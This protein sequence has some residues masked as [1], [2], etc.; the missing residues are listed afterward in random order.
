M[1]NLSGPI[2]ALALVLGSMAAMAQ[3]LNPIQTIRDSGINTY[4][5][6]ALSPDG[7]FAYQCGNDAVT[8]LSRDET[9]GQLTFAAEYVDGVDG[10]DGVAGCIATIVSPDG[11]HLYVGGF[12]ENKI[13]QFDRDVNTG[14]LTLARVY[15]D[16]EN[17]VEAEG[18]SAFAFADA[19]NYLYASATTESRIVAF[20]RD[21]STG[22]LTV[23]N[24]AEGT[25]GD[26]PMPAPLTIVV[27]PDEAFL[28][29]GSINNNVYTCTRNISDGSIALVQ[30]FASGSNLFEFGGPADLVIAPDGSHVYLASIAANQIVQMAPDPGTG[31]LTEVAAFDAGTLGLPS[32]LLPSNIEITPDGSEIYVASLVDSRLTVLARDNVTGA[33]SLV[34]SQ[35][36]VVP[37]TANVSRSPDGAHLYVSGITDSE[38]QPF[39]T[40]AGFAPLTPT[41]NPAAIPRLGVQGI[42]GS[43]GIAMHPSGDFVYVTGIVEAALATFTRDAETGRL[44]FASATRNGDGSTT[45]LVLSR[46]LYMAPD[47]QQLYVARNGGSTI[48]D[49][50]ESTGT[51]TQ[52]ATIEE[53]INGVTGFGSGSTIIVPPDGRHFYAADDKLILIMNRDPVTGIHTVSQVPSFETLGISN[54][55]N[56]GPIRGFDFSSD[57]QFLYGIGEIADFNAMTSSTYVLV[58]SRDPSDGALTFVQEV[59]DPALDSP[60]FQSKITMSPDQEHMYGG[61]RDGLIVYDRDPILG[62]LQPVRSYIDEF[63]GIVLTENLIFSPDGQTLFALGLIGSGNISVFAREPESGLLTQSD[64]LRGGERGITGLRTVDQITLSP[65]G[66]QLYATGITDSTVTVFS[67]GAFIS[68][69]G[70]VGDTV[71]TPLSCT[72]IEL[73]SF[74]ESITRVVVGDSLGRYSFT[75]LPATLYR[76][77]IYGIGVTPTVVERL[78]LTSGASETFEFTAPS[79]VEPPVIFGRILDE[80]SGLPLGGVLVE[81]FVNDELRARTYSC[82]TGEYEVTA[83]DLGL[84]KQLNASVEAVYSSNDFISETVQIEL[85]GEPV[86]QNIS[87]KTAGVDLG[88]LSVAVETT[89]GDRLDNSEVTLQSGSNIITTGVRGN[90]NGANGVFRFDTIPVGPYIVKAASVGYFNGVQATT[91]GSNPAFVTLGLER[92]PAVDLPDP[93]NPSD[94]NNDGSVNAQDIQLVINAVLGV[95]TA[96]GDVN[97]DGII[98]ASDIQEVINTV[99]QS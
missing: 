54:F 89:E 4:S 79:R 95:G 59:A 97:E 17:R 78:D 40:T 2:L 47:G 74:D 41:G 31:L 53:G 27:S 13:A 11:S 43:A 61:S 46:T 94:I 93:P 87:L 30:S 80:D 22:D 49:I 21:P 29:I 23:V 15:V 25:P 84:G 76:A 16:G 52:I 65:D 71:D 5:P 50:D 72:A 26:L 33:L 73:V 98:N 96:A 62:T 60:R 86:E 6:L 45:D 38:I 69:S 9:T 1:R 8:V 28:Y 32:L 18:V 83:G 34:E 14:L 35:A 91:V 67:E 85:Q 3:A 55:A 57:S 63:E 68:L 24:I 99:L 44:T 77:T 75:N 39:A 10:V 19:G 12:S 56:L 7:N 64:L 66:K 90:T 36:N 58:F 88:T 82:A 81:F 37:G 70:S 51:P 92:N 42:E 48:F 20:A